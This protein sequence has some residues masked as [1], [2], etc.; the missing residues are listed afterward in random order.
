META[1]DGVLVLDLSEGVPGPFAARL[2]GDFGAD[3]LKV[4]R[5]PGGDVTRRWGPFPNDNPDPEASGTFFFLNFNKTGITLDWKTR[6]GRELLKGLARRTD[7]VVESSGGRVLGEELREGNPGLVVVSIAGYGEGLLEDWK[8]EDIVAVGHGGPMH[9]TGV[10]EWEPLKYG[11][12][13]ASYQAGLLA[14]TA[15]L[16]A[17]STAEGTGEGDWVEVSRLEA[18]AGTIDRR[19]AFILG[20]QHTGT[21]FGRSPSAT[22]IATGTWPCKDG[23]INIW[24]RGAR[25]PMVLE[26]MGCQDLLSDPRFSQI[27]E[28]SKP[29]NSYVFN[30]EYFLPWL[31]ERTMQEA[32]EAAQKHKIPSGPMFTPANVLADA[33]FN[34]RGVWEEVEHPVLGRV[35][36]PGRP[37]IM[38]QTP[39]RVRRPAPLLGQAN[40]QVFQSELGFSSQGLVRLRQLGVV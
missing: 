30:T 2:L 27:E 11:D 3:V 31:L 1:L 19:L 9:A 34:E 13:V 14:A 6:T 7:I 24:G 17:F 37:F 28:W 21:V 25:F 23:Y 20:Y 5:P 12:D 16:T 36:I 32:W 33:H 10:P 38:E 35:T 22:G 40:G 29:D 26:M 4:E 18:Q 8:L 39:W 15:A